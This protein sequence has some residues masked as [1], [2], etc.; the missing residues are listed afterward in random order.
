MYVARAPRPSANGK[1]Y[2]SIY[3]GQSFRDGPHVRKRNLANLTHCAPEEVA[4]IELALRHKD[5]LAVLGSLD[6]IQLTQ[7]P[8]VDAVWTVWEAARR[9]GLVQA[10][11]A[12]FAG[13]LALW[14][15]LAR[16]LDHGS[17]LSAVRLAQV[18]AAG[19]VLGLRRGLGENDLY[20]S[21]TWLSQH[22]PAIEERLFAARRGRQQPELF[23]YPSPAAIW[24]AG[25]T[26]TASTA[27]TG[28]ARRA[29]NRS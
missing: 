19:D 1:V 25:R 22:Q 5:N 28:T 8:S 10:L 26:P 20:A 18:H 23:R 16:V 11:G 2:T 27:T 15:V 7:G 12:D 13:Q 3:V 14:Q 24:K 29:R 21:L 17:R 6:S 9:L 4:A